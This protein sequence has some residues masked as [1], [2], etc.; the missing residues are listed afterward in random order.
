[1]LILVRNLC[2]FALIFWLVSGWGGG[3][4]LCFLVYEN[5]GYSSDLY[6]SFYRFTGLELDE[7]Y[8]SLVN[9]FYPKIWTI[10]CWDE[11]TAFY[12]AIQHSFS[13]SAYTYSKKAQTA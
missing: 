4:L 9:L 3:G 13:T 8:L 11:L 10:I 7:L 1:M 5:G 12:F 6:F 2:S